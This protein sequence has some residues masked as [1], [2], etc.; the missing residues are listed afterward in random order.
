MNLNLKNTPLTYHDPKYLGLHDLFSKA[1]Q[2]PF[3]D[4]FRF[5]NP[6]LDFLKGRH[7]QLSFYH[8]ICLSNIAL[9]TAP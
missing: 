5:K 7:P 2:K 6:F 3:L 9:A 8:G 4:S 1:R